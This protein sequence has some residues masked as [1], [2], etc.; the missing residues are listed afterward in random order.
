[1]YYARA[2]DLTMLVTLSS[3]A[4]EQ[5]HAK[6]QTE[7]YVHELLDYLHTHKDA[8]IWYVASGMVLN[9]HSNASYL[10]KPKAGSRLGGTYF[11]GS[12]PQN[13]KAI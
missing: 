10:S 7:Q 1:M 8:T 9:I 3:I 11:L 4:S 13:R 5:A 2:V 12:L 6:E